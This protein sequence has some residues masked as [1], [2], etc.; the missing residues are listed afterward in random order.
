MAK[1]RT[2]YEIYIGV[3][4]VRRITNGKDETEM[5]TLIEVTEQLKTTPKVLL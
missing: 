2:D 4:T 3:R 1:K 5:K